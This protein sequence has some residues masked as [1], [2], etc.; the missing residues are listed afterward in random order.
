MILNTKSIFA[1]LGATSLAACSNTAPEVSAGEDA[2]AVV[3]EEFVL[4][5]VRVD[6]DSDFLDDY[7][8]ELVSRPDSSEAVLEDTMT[9]NPYFTPDVVGEYVVEVSASDGDSRSAPDRVTITARIGPEAVITGMPEAMMGNAGGVLPGTTV[10]LD[11]GASTVTTDQMLTLEWAIVAQPVDD[12]DTPE[13]EGSKIE[14]S[15][16]DKAMEMLSFTLMK[17]GVYTFQLTVSDADFSSTTTYT[18]AVREP[19]EATFTVL[20]PTNPSVDAAFTFDA[21]ESEF[22][23]GSSKMYEWT[24]TRAPAG[25]A[26]MVEG[27]A[28]QVT[29]TPDV[30]GEY[31]ITLVVSDGTFSSDPVTATI[32]ASDDTP[33]PDPMP[34]IPDPMPVPMP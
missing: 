17:K 7:Q 33:T 18:V 30:T 11:A 19:P 5:P 21:S 29:F 27:E 8:W 14:L 24:V 20:A 16:A 10:T 9:P 15:D 25:S 2:P 4:Q 13:D 6:E 22:G 1:L 12:E 23:P 32:I 26:A 31:D 3:G 28:A 34:P